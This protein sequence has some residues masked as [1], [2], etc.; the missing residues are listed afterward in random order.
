MY[1][2]GIS[3]V[4][5]AS[6]GCSN[7]R[8]S[9]GLRLVVLVHVDAEGNCVPDFSKGHYA[10]VHVH[11]QTV[12]GTNEGPLAKKNLK[13]FYIS[14]N[15]KQKSECFEIFQKD[16]PWGPW[17]GTPIFKNPSHPIFLKWPFFWRCFFGRFWISKPI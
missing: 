13:I 12:G 3:C 9:F 8:Q 6:P 7:L 2:G 5:S 17:G 11:V 14:D 1:L 10:V 4:A 16:Q 15:L